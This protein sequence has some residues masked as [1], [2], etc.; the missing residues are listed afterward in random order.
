M[1]KLSE[2][3]TGFV[4]AHRMLTVRYS[5]FIP[6]INNG[7]IIQQGTHETLM[8]RGGFCAKLCNS[9]FGTEPESS[10]S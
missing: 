4:I 7:D 5:D 3:R 8:A 6:V 2:K 10:A 9:R 1:D